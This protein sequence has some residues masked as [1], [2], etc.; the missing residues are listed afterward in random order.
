MPSDLRLH[1]QLAAPVS[2]LN[3]VPSDQWTGGIVMLGGLKAQDSAE[4]RLAMTWT[5][6]R[7]MRLF[8]AVTPCMSDIPKSSRVFRP[9]D[10]GPG[11]SITSFEMGNV[12][13]LLHTRDDDL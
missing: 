11:L 3:P 10:P 9:A 2:G 4:T 1:T 5:G 12:V 13:I 6:T 8:Q 7:P